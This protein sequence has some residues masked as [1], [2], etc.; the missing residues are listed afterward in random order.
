MR[1][2]QRYSIIDFYFNFIV[3]REYIMYNLNFFYIYWDIL[4][5]RIC[6]VFVNIP[7]ALEKTMYSA[8]VGSG[9]LKCQLS[10]ICL[11]SSPLYPYRCSV[12]FFYQLYLT[13]V[14]DLPIF[15]WSSFFFLLHILWSSIIR[16][17]NV[18]DFWSFYL[19]GNGHSFY[20]YPTNKI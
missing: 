13:I 11:F 8:V 19:A 10:Q 5:L 20:I 7:R 17:I 14:V 1:I 4:W 2:S 16:C 12:C 9:V 3:F 6:S 15:T 18:Y